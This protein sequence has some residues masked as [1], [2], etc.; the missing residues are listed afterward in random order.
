MADQDTPGA[1]P[2]VPTDAAV[3]G[4]AGPGRAPTAVPGARQTDRP[5]R[6]RARHLPEDAE[7]EP[8][9][10]VRHGRETGG[11]IYVDRRTIERALATTRIPAST[12]IEELEVFR[13]I[14]GG[15]PTEA[16]VLLVIRPRKGATR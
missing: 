6:N 13:R 8:V 1:R 16:Q 5:S 14:L 9:L 12:P 11:R 7:L 2:A 10:F 3:Y 15:H 4:Q